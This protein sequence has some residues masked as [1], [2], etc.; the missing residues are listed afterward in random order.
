MTKENGVYIETPLIEASAE[1]LADYGILIGEK[2]QKPGLSI[3]FYKGSVEEGQ[4]LEFLYN[5]KAVVRTARIA[6]RPF[7]VIWLERHM[8]MSQLFVGLGNVPF[9]MVLGKPNHQQG[10]N[11]PSV[12]DVRAFRISGG[13]GLMLHPGT[14]HDFPMAIATAV[15]VLTMNSEEVVQALASMEEAGE[16]DKGDVFKIDVEKRTGRVIRVAFT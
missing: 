3:P 12:E 6:P 9:V 4:N 1:N 5:G 14:W 8:R 10:A 2:V 15:T 13:H 11:A 16:M 7:D